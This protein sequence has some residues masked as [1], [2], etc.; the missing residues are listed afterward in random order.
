M[1][2]NAWLS[3]GIVCSLGLATFGFP[4]AVSAAE[5]AKP[6]SVSKKARTVTARYAPKVIR[7]QNNPFEEETEI[8][9][10]TAG[11]A[12]VTPVSATEPAAPDD[13]AAVEQP[14]ITAEATV[15]PTEDS[16]NLDSGALKRLKD[17]SAKERMEKVHEEWLKNRKERE[18]QPLQTR[19]SGPAKSAAADPFLPEPSEATQPELPPNASQVEL[20]GEASAPADVA[21]PVDQALDGVPAER[22]IKAPRMDAGR[23]RLQSQPKPLTRVPTEEEMTKLYQGDNSERLAPPVRDPSQ[24]PRITDIQPVPKTRNP[25]PGRQIPEENSKTYVRL[26]HTPFTNRV[27]PEFLYTWEATNFNHQPL[28]FED[29]ALE[30]YGHVLPP[31]LQPIVSIGKFSGQ[32]IFLP[33][34]MVLNPPTSRISPLGWYAPGDYVPYKMYQAPLNAKAAA[35][36]AALILGVHFGSP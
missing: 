35:V 21:A 25:T 27:S 36:E 28:Y 26:G 2:V 12:R 22:P 23:V 3:T 30:R 13:A 32:L 20:P 14:A 4:T 10:Q 17:R 19:P 9:S 7:A 5:P 18:N 29:P 8:D 1:Q 24:L 34:Q 31:Y 15:A 6:K 11:R 33:Y 16:S